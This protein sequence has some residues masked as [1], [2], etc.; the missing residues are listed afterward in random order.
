[1]KSPSIRSS[2]PG[3]SGLSCS[4]SDSSEELLSS[5]G[6]RLY[7]EQSSKSSTSISR[8]NSK[9]GQA[10]QVGPERSG[11]DT[12]VFPFPFPFLTRRCALTSSQLMDTREPQYVSGSE[13]D[14]D[15][16]HRPPKRAR[17]SPPSDRARTNGRTATSSSSVLPP[18]SLSILGV[19]PLDEF[20]RE[21]ADFVHHSIANR[22]ADLQGEI[23]VEAKIGVLRE[24]GT[25]NRLQLPV[26]VET[27]MIFVAR[28]ISGDLPF[29]SVLVPKA[30]DCHFES[31]M[32]Q[33]SRV[34]TLR[35]L[36]S[37]PS[38]RPNTNIIT[39]FLTSSKKHQTNKD[40]IH[41]PSRTP[42]H[43]SLTHS[44]RPRIRG[45]GRRFA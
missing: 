17:H 26:L 43:I 25:G 38:S 20:I 1:M 13:S 21:V 3:S 10:D 40:T 4:S 27:S 5:A 41:R 39:S 31:N 23:E 16:A 32:S 45:I 22:P 34:S 7:V 37:P 24:R 44:M 35:R 33:V 19:E 12:L 14:A 9:L 6:E 29:C 2:A 36:G 28:N 15:Y 30:A 42:I 11:V 18:L 8:F